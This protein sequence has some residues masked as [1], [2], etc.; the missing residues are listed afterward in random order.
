RQ[1]HHP[2]RQRL[3]VSVTPSSKVKAVLMNFRATCIG[4][5]GGGNTT[6][7][8][9]PLVV[10]PFLPDVLRNFASRSTPVVSTFI[11][12]PPDHAISLFVGNAIDDFHQLAVC[13]RRDA[14]HHVPPP[15]QRDRYVNIHPA[16]KQMP[17]DAGCGQV[18]VFGNR[19]SDQL[20][21]L[22]RW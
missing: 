6:C 14:M 18:A 10:A 1:I 12:W 5:A 2:P 21:P 15:H 8:P 16:P 9:L 17:D 20:F 11:G 7:L 3:S 19:T 4:R 13:E 22:G